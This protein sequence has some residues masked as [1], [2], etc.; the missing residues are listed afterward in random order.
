MEMVAKKMLRKSNASTAQRNGDAF[1]SIKFP[2][3]L[4]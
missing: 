3:S 1:S 2:L 4:D